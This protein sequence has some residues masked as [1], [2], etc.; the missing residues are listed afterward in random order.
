MKTNAAR[1]LDMAKVT[2]EL[3]QYEVTQEDLS[4]ATVAKKV[5]APLD[6]VYK[7]L[8]C[9][10][11]KLGPM[12]AVVSGDKEIDLKR[13]ASVAKERKCQL[14]ALKEVQPL[15]GYIRGGVTV[16]GAKKPFPVYVDSDLLTH[17]QI[18]V[19]GGMRG[20]Q[21]LLAPE[22]YVRVTAATLVEQL[23]H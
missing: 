7:T 11:D 1:I 18:S 23:G 16:L 19:S 17:D 12:F 4:A 5:N 21:I 13:L 6:C 20:L 3:R 9:R 10:G 8:V 14:V 15:T 2:Y 22:D